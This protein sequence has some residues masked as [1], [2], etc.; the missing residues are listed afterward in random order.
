VKSRLTDPQK[1]RIFKKQ[2]AK[3]RK[4]SVMVEIFL[5]IWTTVFMAMMSE[6]VGDWIWNFFPYLYF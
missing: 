5:F 4:D 1:L 2:S 3:K 6:V